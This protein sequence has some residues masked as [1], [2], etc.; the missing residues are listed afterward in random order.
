MKKNIKNIGVNYK[1]IIRILIDV[2]KKVLLFLF[3]TTL[4]NGIVPAIS[5]AFTQKILNAVQTICFPLNILMGIVCAYIVFNVLSTFFSIIQQYYTSLFQYKLDQ[6]IN[7]LILEKA[8][9]LSLRDYENAESYDKI[10]RAKAS[11]K[12]YSYFSYFL[13]IIELIVT[14]IMYIY[15][16]MS[17]KWWVIFVIIFVSIISAMLMNRVNEYRYEMLR[18]RTGEEREK[19]YYQF[20]LTNDLAF[21]E[22]KTY[23]L[24]KY[25]IDKYEKIYIKFLNQDKQYLKKM[26]KI[27]VIKSI[28]E[29]IVSAF[30]LVLIILDTY[31]GKILIG[32]SVAYINVTNSVKNVIRL[33]LQQ[34]SS[35]YNDS[36]YI[37]QIFELLSLPSERYYYKGT[38]EIGSIKE[39]VLKNVSYKYSGCN[40]YALENVSLVL[41]T[42]MMVALVGANG[43]GKSTLVKIISGLYTEYEGEVFVNGINLKDI[44]ILSFRKQISTLFQDYTKYELSLRENIA[45]GNIENISN[46]AEIKAVLNRVGLKKISNLDQ[47]L[48]VWFDNGIQLSGG[49]WIKVGLGRAFFKNS[50]LIILDEPDASL[51]GVAETEIY[52]QITLLSKDKIC[53]FITHHLTRIPKE[54]QYVVLEKGKIVGTGT[55]EKLVKDCK[56]YKELYLAKETK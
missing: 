28:Q 21:K 9:D 36:L 38:R 24:M 39:I 12:I 10:Q 2:D 18:E 5:I 45:I 53:L 42:E 19:W 26:S 4:I 52:K 23:N 34:F 55:H 31:A 17:W 40:E 25:F 7:M 14:L 29:E 41:K 3:I 13:S 1:K 15:M 27:S 50:S 16:L 33:L 22:I 30:C 47:R 49:E 20:L 56:V 46:D 6:Y 54:T 11:N 35:I 37:S 51:D 8:G 43:S 48:G 44:D 32:D